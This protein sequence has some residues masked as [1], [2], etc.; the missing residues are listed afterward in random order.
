[1][2]NKHSLTETIFLVID[3]ITQIAVLRSVYKKQ[4]I[5]SG[6]SK[7]RQPPGSPHHKI[8]TPKEQGVII[9][10]GKPPLSLLRKG[11]REGRRQ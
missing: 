3:F 10:Q 9:T 8:I 5:D 1:M 7:S 4:T 2:R 11:G 6:H